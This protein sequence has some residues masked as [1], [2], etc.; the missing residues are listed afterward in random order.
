M[1]NPILAASVAGILLTQNIA[2]AGSS[3]VDAVGANAIVKGL[4]EAG[5][6]KAN[7][8]ALDKSLEKAEAHITKRASQGTLAKSISIANSAILTGLSVMAFSKLSSL[9]TLSNGMNLTI[10][11]STGMS[12]IGHSVSLV[13]KS[14]NDIGPAVE[15]LSVLRTQVAA[16]LANDKHAS[17]EL[18]K[19]NDHLEVLAISMSNYE[20]QVSEEA[21]LQLKSITAQTV[22]LAI[23]TLGSLKPRAS[24]GM[25]T[26][27]F[28]S[29]VLVAGSVGPLLLLTQDDHSDE[30]LAKIKEVRSEINAALNGI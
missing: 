8:V 25:A 21:A 7:L 12:V 4:E 2:V 17:A 28:G 9:R 3:R 24:S 15:S 26:A 20:A 18:K 5:E 16:E 13:D 23:S 11:L 29:L 30:L 22:G 27:Y 1:K 10:A 19:L 14:K 6:L